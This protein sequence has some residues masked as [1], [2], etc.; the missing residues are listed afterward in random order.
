MTSWYVLLVFQA[1]H[2]EDRLDGPSVQ[3]H[4]RIGW[5]VIFS[6]VT[7]L[8]VTTAM[9]GGCHRTGQIGTNLGP[10]GAISLHYMIFGNK[11]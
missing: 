3:N 7:R 9:V 10:I 11:V 4:S 2:L 1:M 6:T 8:A 5:E